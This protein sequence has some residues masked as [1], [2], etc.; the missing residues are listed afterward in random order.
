MLTA[1]SPASL[2]IFARRRAKRPGQFFAPVDRLADGANRSPERIAAATAPIRAPVRTALAGTLSGERSAIHAPRAMLQAAA[3][4]GKGRQRTARNP[5]MPDRRRADFNIGAAFDDAVGGK[6]GNRAAGSRTGCAA[7]GRTIHRLHLTDEGAIFAERRAK[8]FAMLAEAAEEATAGARSAS[9]TLRIGLPPL[10]G[11]YLVGPVLPGLLARH[12]KLRVELKTL[13][14]LS[15][16]LNAG[17]DC[18]IA[19]G[20]LPDS[21]LAATVYPAG[22]AMPRRVRVFID[23]MLAAGSTLPGICPGAG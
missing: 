13:L 2:A 5:G 8:A 23:Y 14:R 6:Q 9:G 1:T 15:D 4:A 22:R 11:T 19:A 17:M 10:F 7:S 21:S 3:A 16:F 20:D 12:P 18:A